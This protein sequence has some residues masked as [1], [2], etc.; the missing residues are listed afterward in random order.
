MLW[1]SY[2]EVILRRAAVA[3]L[4]ALIPVA[5]EH[6][7]QRQCLPGYSQHGRQSGCLD[8]CAGSTTSTN[9][10]SPTTSCP[11]CRSISAATAEST[12]PES[13]TATVRLRPPVVA[14]PGTGLG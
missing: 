2:L 9:P 13:P 8:C 4:V 14:G 3:A 1:S 11:A 7:C 12:P 10:R 5:H 6:T